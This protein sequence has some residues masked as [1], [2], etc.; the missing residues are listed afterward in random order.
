QGLITEVSSTVMRQIEAES[1]PIRL[2][3]L[4]PG[5]PLYVSGDPQQLRQVFLNLFINSMD[6]IEGPGEI[7]VQ[8]LPHPQ[9]L[10][11]LFKDTGCG[12]KKEDLGRVF[13]PFFT[14]KPP[15]KG[16]GLGLSIC[17]SIIQAHRG[18][19]EATS[20]GPGRGATFKISLP[21]LE[22]K[23]DGQK[24]KGALRRG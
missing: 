1:R 7:T 20:D 2:S 6:A 21:L 12:I 11:L 4:L 19:I 17:Y 14:T 15:G 22:A 23:G 9:K 18:N 3:L 5:K 8:T 13:D 16:T 10:T 24:A